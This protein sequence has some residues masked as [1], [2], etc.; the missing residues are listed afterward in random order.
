MPYRSSPH[1]ESEILMSFDY[2]H[3]IGPDENNKDGNF[4]FEIE[5]K[6][7]IHVGEKLYSF[8]TNDEIE[9]YFSEHGYN[10]VKFSFARGKENI[11]FMLHQKYIPMQEYENSTV[12]NE[13]Q[14]LYKKDDEIKGDNIT[15]EN[16][17]N[18][19]Y[20]NNFLN[21]KIVHSKQ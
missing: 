16:E 21:C 4:L 15:V 17:G 3:V 1:R 7:Y 18:V 5:N 11:Y 13:Y 6:K 2:L 10:D 9:E 14:Y 19:E 8:E 20:G 12:K